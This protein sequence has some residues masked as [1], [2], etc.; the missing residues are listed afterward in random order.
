MKVAR[1]AIAATVADFSSLNAPKSLAQKVAAYLLVEQRTNELDSL[2]RDVMQVR[3]SRGIVE[4]VAVSAHE[5]DDMAIRDIK[6]QVKQLFPES[7]E[8][9][10]SPKLDASIIGGIKLEFANQQLDLS[11]KSK[12]NRMRQL[13]TYGK[14]V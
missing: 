14:D 5:L 9:I 4:V 1:T 6:A 7:K 2:M 11:V 12:L 10:V 8:V 3:A 13:I